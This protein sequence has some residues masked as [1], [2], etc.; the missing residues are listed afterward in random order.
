MIGWPYLKGSNG[1]RTK[2][3]SGSRTSGLNHLD[4]NFSKGAGAA[5]AQP[6]AT[7]LPLLALTCCSW[8]PQVSAASL[9][10]QA[11]RYLLSSKSHLLQPHQT[12]VGP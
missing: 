5:T 6:L 12:L 3:R 8:W 9:S 10:T 2:F 1:R 4:S 7:F 11:L